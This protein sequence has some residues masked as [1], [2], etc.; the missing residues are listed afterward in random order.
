MKAPL[1]ANTAINQRRFNGWL[2]DFH[3]YRHSVSQG[4]V[5][6]WLNQFDRND[7]DLGARVLDAVDFIGQPQIAAAL[8]NSLNSIPGWNKAESR[9]EG[10]WRFAAYS[11]SAGE[12]GDT[13]LHHF[14][15][16]NGLDSRRFKHLFVHRSELL[17]QGLGTDDTLVLIDDFV[18]TGDQVCNAWQETFAELVT[19]IGRVYLIVV[20][21]TRH[22]FDRIQ[23]DTELTLSPS[24]WL[25][26]ADDLFSSKCRHFSDDEKTRILKYCRTA[27]RNK[28]KGWGECGL[29]VVFQH[30]CPNDSIPILHANHSK[31]SGLFRRHDLEL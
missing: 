22:A 29:V 27:D 24:K 28:P 16:A 21:A 9:R 13:M 12:S 26:E 3:G 14:R 15:L 1:P 4:V 25:D 8:R 18:G 2:N 11:S 19:G 17:L 5:E 30:R 6:A 31:W 23:S 10:Q 20:A 7:R